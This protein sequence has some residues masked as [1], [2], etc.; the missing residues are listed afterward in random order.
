MPLATRSSAHSAKCAFAARVTPAKR[1][2][3]GVFNPSAAAWTPTVATSGRCDTGRGGRLRLQ[4][5][6]QAVQ[7]LQQLHERVTIAGGD[8]LQLPDG[9]RELRQLAGR[10][11]GALLLQLR[12]RLRGLCCQSLDA[13]IR[14]RLLLTERLHLRH[15]L[16]L[17]DDAPVPPEG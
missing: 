14:L 3:T 1:S 7:S 9:G 2:D 11:V 15:G 10:D 16:S 6:R 12:Q 8:R 13:G 4:S 5:C 17:G